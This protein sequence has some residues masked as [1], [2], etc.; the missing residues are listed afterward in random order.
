MSQVRQ[1]KSEPSGATVEVSFTRG[2]DEVRFEAEVVDGQ[3]EVRVDER[4]ADGRSGG[5][6]NSTADDG[7]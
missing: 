7:R 3:V 5:D 6:D 2:A 1:V 4:P